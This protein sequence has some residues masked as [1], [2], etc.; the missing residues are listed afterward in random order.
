MILEREEELERL[1]SVLDDA[2]GQVVLVRGEAGIG[3]TTLIDRFSAEVGDCARVLMGRCD[4]LLTPQP[5][6][7]VYDIARHEPAVARSLAE[8][9]RR[10]VMESLLELLS[11]PPRPTVLIIEDTQ[12]ADEATLDA[13]RFLGRRIG[14]TDG[15]LVLTY[16]D[17]EVA[18]DHPLRQVIGQLPPANVVRLQ[19]QPLSADAVSA[20]I[21]E[22]LFP[23][24]E[25][26][27]LTGGNPLFVAEVVASGTE[28]VPPS[29][30]DSVLA[31]ASKVSPA[32]RQL[33]HVAAVVPGGMERSL[34]QAV[35]AP[36]PGHLNECVQHGLLS[37]VGDTVSFRHELQR[38]AVESAIPVEDRRALNQ[39]ILDL[40]GGRGEPARLV[41][42]AREAGDV[43][44]LA[45]HA[46][47]AARLAASLG[48]QREAVAHFRELA[49]HTDRFDPAE[50]A[51]LLEDWARSET[52]LGDARAVELVTEAIALR[53][54][55]GDDV[56]LGRT[57]TFAV[58]VYERNAMTE[59]ADACAEEA[60]VLL[61][62]RPPSAALAAALTQ[63]AWLCFMRGTEDRR[64]A[65]LAEQAVQMAEEVDDEL[66]AVR[67]MTWKGAIAYNSGDRAGFPLVEEA[68]QRAAKAGFRYEETIALVNLAGMSADVREVARAADLVRRARDTAARHEI[69]SLEAYTQAMYA[70]ILLWQGDWETAEDTAAVALDGAPH[71]AIVAWRV[72]GQLQARRGRSEAD[73]ILDRVW[74][75]AEQTGELQQ[76]DPAASVLAEYAWLADDH[77]EDRLAIIAST[78]ERSLQAGPPW[79]SGAL[80][81]WAWKLGLLDAI[82]EHT[83]HHYR[84][85]I[86]GWPEVAAE[87]WRSRGVPYEEALALMHGQEQDRLRAL[88][89]L[90]GLGARAAA[91]RVRRGLREEGVR[92][93][94]GR[95]VSARSHAAGLTARQA[96][97]L[98]LLAEG[99]S[100]PE[101]ADRLFISHR[102]VE[103]HVAA[104][105]MKLDVPDRH[106]AVE[107]ARDVGLVRGS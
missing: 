44:A 104:V 80:V 73:G 24:D 102:T 48:S 41:H 90:E 54:A 26:L 4:D 95:S 43:E 12:W 13:I 35:L 15:V 103:N 71:A 77:D 21:G 78:T 63:Q 65:E 52:D 49:A 53:R 57:L 89:I 64:A 88:E 1:S 19:L 56:A 38:R 62:A 86:E 98:D 29:V 74:S 85:I 23:A 30:Q 11:R 50:R 107:F 33:L 58:S 97:V 83:P 106:A 17:G 69:P 75:L 76:L 101:I 9:D 61:G 22:R 60:V 81:F 42:H 34:L 105:L 7:P 40:L 10:A 84:A 45:E 27:A 14:R 18:G 5:F 16:R 51:A 93:P 3:K 96:E 46:P 55:L 39:R 47:L 31:R 36:S 82:P 92:V 37:V 25:V 66:A 2:D 91:D 94:R 68:H 70:E 79:P 6:A 72:L 8:G 99:L 28:E 32:A 59:A 20:M 87:F 100:N 67:A